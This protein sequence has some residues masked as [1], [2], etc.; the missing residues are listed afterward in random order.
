MEHQI[1]FDQELA[2]LKRAIL[3]MGNLVQGLIERSVRAIKERDK[4]LAKSVIKDD[5]LVDQME[6]EIDDRSINLIAIR[7]PKAVDLR[8]IMTGLRIATDLERIGDLAEDIAERAIELAEQPLLKPLIDIPR[9]AALAQ[10]AVI[11]S[12]EAFVKDDVRKARA[13]WEIEKEVDHLRDL[14]HDE[15]LGI[16]SKDATAI[17]R[18]IPLLLVSRHLERISDHATNIAEDVVYMVEGKVVKH[19]GEKPV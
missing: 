17:S 13:I 10:Q 12:L 3:K 5:V 9:M 8:T 6:L 19:G 4:N 11:F 1:L 14:V 15:L 18:G 2:E 16:M 7:Q